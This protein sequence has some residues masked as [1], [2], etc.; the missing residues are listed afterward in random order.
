M[1]AVAGWA[2][3]ADGQLLLVGRLLAALV[4]FW[5]TLEMQTWQC[6]LRAEASRAALPPIDGQPLA[7]AMLLPSR[8][9]SRGISNA[10]DWD[11]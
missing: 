4:I 7:L 5:Y 11:G 9:E 3:E 10:T 1:I 6:F 8:T 2:V